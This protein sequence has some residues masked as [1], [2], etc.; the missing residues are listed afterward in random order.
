MDEGTELYLI[1]LEGFFKRFRFHIMQFENDFQAFIKKK[2]T[3]NQISL[4]IE[5]APNEKNFT[6]ELLQ[7]S[8]YLTGWKTKKSKT[9]QFTESY[10][11]NI[12]LVTRFECVQEI[13]QIMF[14][15]N[16]KYPLCDN[17]E[18]HPHSEIPVPFTYE[19]LFCQV[20]GK[21]IKKF[22]VLMEGIDSERIMFRLEKYLGLFRTLSIKPIHSLKEGVFEENHFSFL[23][24][25]FISYLPDDNLIL[26][27]I[28]RLNIEKI[29]FKI[30][31]SLIFQEVDISSAQLTINDEKIPYT[32]Q[33]NTF[34]NENSIINLKHPDLNQLLTHWLD[35]S[36]Q[37]YETFEDEF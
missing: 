7:D 20:C 29:T 31:F 24:L 13:Y 12:P 21:T 17:K 8:T 9:D 6:V 34:T 2:A 32:E 28:F 14:P 11:E 4:P 35:R 15:N 5:K 18:I 25:P 22:D 27:D 26:V 3:I 37:N 19:G 16:E 23:E 10:M 33:I 1:L 30:I 36:N